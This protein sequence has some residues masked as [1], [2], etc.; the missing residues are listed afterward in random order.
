MPASGSARAAALR[1]V[2]WGGGTAF[3]AS[4]LWFLYCYLVDFDRRPARPLVRGL[5][6]DVALFTLFAAH[7]SVLARSGPRRVVHQLVP[8]ALERSLYTW[9]A[10]IL[11]VL[12]CT[13]WQALPGS[14]YSLQGLWRVVAY[15]VQLLGIVLTIQGSAV[16]DVLDLAG[17]RPVLAA[18]AGAPIRHVPLET[19][20]LYGFVRHPIYFGWALFVF[21]TPEMT[22]TRAAFAV[23]SSGY[24][25]LAI[26]WEE[27]SL[28]RVFGA[29]YE[30]YRRKVRWRMLPGIY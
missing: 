24:L 17:V 28:V 5:T 6:L 16:L 21:G 23:V 1:L 18:Q 12:V 4:L 3:L 22:A 8:A 13:V 26:P 2:A 14:F 20:G 7:H 15:T 30:A 27:R 19:R 10:S 25:A 29:D 9:V 11:F